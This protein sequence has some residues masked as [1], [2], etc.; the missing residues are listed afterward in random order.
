MFPGSAQRASINGI[1]C[2]L[3]VPN[4][5]SPRRRRP[6]AAIAI[7]CR[8]RWTGKEQ[9]G[10]TSFHLLFLGMKRSFVLTPSIGGDLWLRPLDATQQHR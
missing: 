4:D 6:L 5:S 7:F 2:S 9:E 8:S 10:V 3:M 1:Y